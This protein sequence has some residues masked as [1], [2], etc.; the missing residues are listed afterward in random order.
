MIS[1]WFCGVAYVD[2]RKTVKRAFFDLCGAET[3]FGRR[4]VSLGVFLI[5]YFDLML[6]GSVC[7]RGFIFR[8]A[9]GISLHYSAF[10]HFSLKS[11]CDL[12]ES[13]VTDSIRVHYTT[14]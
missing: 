4:K 3:V 10:R 2:V 1:V 14:R 9:F 5:G 13:T 12:A 7:G 8:A 11:A 6:F